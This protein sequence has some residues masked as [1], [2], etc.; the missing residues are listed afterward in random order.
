MKKKLE[1]LKK[2]SCRCL[3][4]KFG[5]ARENNLNPF[6]ANFFF[7]FARIFVKLN[8]FLSAWAQKHLLKVCFYYQA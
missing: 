3:F 1:E 5:L 4:A 8:I 6:T 7:A 2:T